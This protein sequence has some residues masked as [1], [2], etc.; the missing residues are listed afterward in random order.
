MFDYF[1]GNEP[2]QYAFYS[3][4]QV[5]FI[6]DM[7]KQMSCESKVLYGLML[8]KAGLSVKNGWI[9]KKG[10]VYVYFKRDDVCE[11]L[12]CKK[13]KATKILNELDD[14]KGIGLIERVAQGQGK[15]DRIYVKHFMRIIDNNDGIPASCFDNEESDLDINKNSEGGTENETA[16][17]RAEKPLSRRRN[18]RPLD[19]EKTASLPINQTKR[20]NLIEPSYQSNQQK[21]SQT[22]ATDNRISNRMIEKNDF[23]DSNIFEEYEELIKENIEYDWFIEQ[24]EY[25]S[26]HKVKHP[27]PGSIEELDEIVAIMVDVICSNSPTIRVANQDFPQE[28]VKNRFLKLTQVHIEYVFNSLAHNTTNVINPKAYMITTLYNSLLTL[29]SSENAGFR[30]CFPEYAN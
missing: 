2:K 19:G 5:L 25:Q 21:G 28:V 30:H 7:F 6:D 1:Y 15:P 10:R 23:S 17:K 14:K 20:V 16:F 11:M 4:P 13:D 29:K 12:G 3:I 9:D 26:R 24:Y 22:A 18:N 27:I 8:D